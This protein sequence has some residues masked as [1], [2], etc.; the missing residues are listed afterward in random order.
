MNTEQ[1]FQNLRQQLDQLDTQA[2]Q[3]RIEAQ[4]RLAWAKQ[5]SAQPSHSMQPSLFKKIRWVLLTLGGSAMASLAITTIVI[6]ATTASNQPS[7]EVASQT[8]N[9][10][11]PQYALLAHTSTNDMIAA[12]IYYSGWLFILIITAITLHYLGRTIVLKLIELFHKGKRK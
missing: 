8:A 6:Y 11:N 2:V 7:A 10:V 12:I 1:R 4:L 9:G 3:S 5:P